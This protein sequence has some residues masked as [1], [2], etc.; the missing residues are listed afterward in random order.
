[1][2][3]A[4]FFLHLVKHRVSHL[5]Q[6]FYRLAATAMFLS[7]LSFI[8]RFFLQIQHPLLSVFQL[9]FLLLVITCSR[10]KKPKHGKKNNHR[11]ANIVPIDD[12]LTANSPP[13]TAINETTP[14][15]SRNKSK[16]KKHLDEE[17]SFQL[18]S[19]V[20]SLACLPL[21]ILISGYT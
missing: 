12:H 3:D 9:L 13:L 10:M 5:I 14:K 18:P 20:S 4:N 1:M 11:P 16:P 17:L 2:D 21:R 15:V 7:V 19:S 8:C 6:S